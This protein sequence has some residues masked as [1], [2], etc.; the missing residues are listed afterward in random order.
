MKMKMQLS[1]DDGIHLA[2]HSS[3][4]YAIWMCFQR[5]ESRHKI[6]YVFI[7]ARDFVSELL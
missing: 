7:T 5:H 4:T 1:C 6:S 2:S 3:P